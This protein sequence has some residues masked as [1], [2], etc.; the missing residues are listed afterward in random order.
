MTDR[1]QWRETWSLFGAAPPEKL[2]HELVARYSEPHRFYHTLQHMR[3]CFS[4]LA[5]ASHLAR[6]LIE[7]QLAVW[8]HDAVYDTRAHDNEEQSAYWAE[9]SLIA[10]GVDSDVAVAVGKLVLATKHTVVPEAED[11]KLLVDVDL[12]ILGAT[13]P[14]FT[15]YERQIRQEYGWVAEDVFRQ[16]RADILVLLLNR[17]SI[18]GTG[19]FASR[20]EEQARKNLARSLKELTV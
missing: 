16:R 4:V 15:E 18:Y 9:E 1:E 13:E 6:R 2:F 7:V 14:G 8:F 11:A 3:E 10:E 17:S 5:G 19:W 12:S 20:L